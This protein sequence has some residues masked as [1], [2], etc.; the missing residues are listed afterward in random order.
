MAVTAFKYALSGATLFTALDATAAFADCTTS[1]YNFQF[2]NDTVQALSTVDA[3]GCSYEFSVDGTTLSK[4]SIT[5]KPQHGQLK[6]A[7]RF[8]VQYSP[9]KGYQGADHY[10]IKIC[11]QSG[12]CSTVAYSATVK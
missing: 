1:D 6:Q 12:G 2:S 7:S 9:T 3:G 5:T 11:E 8:T 4:L 10:A